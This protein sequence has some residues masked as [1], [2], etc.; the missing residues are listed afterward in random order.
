MQKRI[1]ALLLAMVIVIGSVLNG[2]TL[3]VKAASATVAMSPELAAEFYMVLL[4]VAETAMHV[5]GA[6]NGFNNKEAMEAIGDGVQGYFVTS[7]SEG[8]DFEFQTTDG[9]T[10]KSYS[11]SGYP[12]GL[13]EYT[14]ADGQTYKLSG[15]KFTTLLLNGTITLDPDIYN[16]TDDE[17]TVDKDDEYVKNM[18]AMFDAKWDELKEIGFDDGSG[19]F[20]NMIRKTELL[21]MLKKQ[22]TI[23]LKC[24]ADCRIS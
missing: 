11:N 19:V 18:K 12:G 4:Q 20:A 23:I 8:V 5:S 2:N 13:V 10:F 16:D 15:D 9:Q 1:S 17:P 24:R 7:M 22:I 3:K 21:C 14:T 6:N